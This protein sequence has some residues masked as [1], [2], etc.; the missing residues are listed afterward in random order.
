MD[1]APYSLGSR[2]QRALKRDEPP[3]VRV[4]VPES[5]SND[6]PL[7]RRILANSASRSARD[8]VRRS[9]ELRLGAISIDLASNG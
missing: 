3:R 2:V 7:P 9:E 8:D 1:D 4:R 6:I 5:E